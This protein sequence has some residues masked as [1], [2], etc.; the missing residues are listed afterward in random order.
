MGKKEDLGN[1]AKSEKEVRKNDVE[2]SKQIQTNMQNINERN[3]LDTYLQ[4]KMK[5]QVK[6]IKHLSK[7]D[8]RQKRKQWRTNSLKYSLRKR[9]N[10]RPIEAVSTSTDEIIATSILTIQDRPSTS[11]IPQ[12]KFKVSE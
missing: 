6:P 5:G 7:C 11:M 10:Q 2:K 3:T 8:Q 1:N 4:R 9:N 12:D